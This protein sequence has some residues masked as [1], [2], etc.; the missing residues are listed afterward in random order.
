MLLFT[1]LIVFLQ[2]GEA[3]YKGKMD[4]QLEKLEK[5]ESKFV[6]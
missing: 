5:V 1:D 2:I 3:K 4:A 6:S